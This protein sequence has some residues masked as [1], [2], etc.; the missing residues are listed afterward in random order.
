M[1]CRLNS[2]TGCVCDDLRGAAKTAT[3]SRHERLAREMRDDSEREN[4]EAHAAEHPGEAYDRN[5]DYTNE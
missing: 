4:R 3:H 2:L 1:S 5:R